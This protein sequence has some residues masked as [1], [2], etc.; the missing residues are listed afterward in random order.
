MELLTPK[1]VQAT[2]KCSL[3]YVYKLH[4]RQLLPAVVFPVMGE[5]TEKPRSM[6]RFKQSD[7]IKFIESH[8]AST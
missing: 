4:E 1:E 8:Y 2:L 6:I 7:V 3:A 5:G